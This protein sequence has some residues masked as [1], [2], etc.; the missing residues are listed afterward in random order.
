MVSIISEGG[1]SSGISLH[2]YIPGDKKPGYTFLRMNLKESGYLPTRA[3]RKQ[4]RPKTVVG[5][6]RKSY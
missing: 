1:E 6:K 3:I 5:L 4:S 2:D